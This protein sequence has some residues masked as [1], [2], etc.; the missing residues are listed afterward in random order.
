MKHNIFVSLGSRLSRDAINKI[1]DHA[2]DILPIR[3]KRIVHFSRS[4]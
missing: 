3:D 1:A 4:R 2:D